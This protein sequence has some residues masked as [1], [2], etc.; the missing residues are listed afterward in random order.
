M[1]KPPNLYGGKGGCN[2]TAKRALV[3]AVVFS[4]LLSLVLITPLSAQG[5]EAVII[6]SGK[7]TAYNTN[8]E[9]DPPL[10]EY[11]SSP[12]LMVAAKVG[13]GAVVA[14]G[15]V[16]TSR[17]T[18][19]NDINN[20]A[21]NFDVLLDKAFQWMVPGATKVL[22]FEGYGVYNTIDAPEVQCQQLEDALEAKGYT[23][24]GDATT[25]ITSSLLSGYDIMVIP[26]MQLGESHTGG[27]PALLPDADVQAIKT[28]VEGGGGL[29]IMD[30]SDYGGHNYYK[31]HN[32][33]LTALDVGFYFQDDQVQDDT[34]QWGQAAYQPIAVVDTTTEIGSAYQ[35]ET[36]KNEIGLYSICSLRI[37]K[38]YEVSVMVSPTIK[39]GAAGEVLTYEVTI[40]NTGTKSDTYTL[41]AEDE[42]GWP[43]TLSK[44][45]ASLEP[46]ESTVVEVRVTV[47]EDLTEKMT[48]WI[49]LTT[50]GVSE[51]DA[52][53]RAI[54]IF[55]REKPP[56]PIVRPDVVR[57]LG[58]GLPTLLVDPPAVPVITAI[59]T[60]FSVDLTPREPWPIL[61]G[62][63]EF[64]PVSAAELIGNGRVIALSNSI[65]RDV[66]FDRPELANDEVM[67]M[68]VRWM[69][70][71]EDPR[72]H[73]LLYW[74]TEDSYH[75]P[76]GTAAPIVTKYVEMLEEGF[77]FEVGTQVGGEI[78]PELI[79]GYDVIQLA[80]ILR[81]LSAGEI[82]AVVDWVNDGGGLIIMCMA[83]YGGYSRP[84]YPNEV[85][86]ALDSGIRFQ[87]DELYDEDSWVV[88][89]PWFPQVYLLDPREAN[90]EFDVWFPGHD[91]A[92]YM[93]VKSMTLESARA[94]FRL[95]LTNVGTADSTYTIEVTETTTPEKLGWNLEVKPTEV[96][97]AVGENVEI[98]TVVTVPDIEAGR[99]RMDLKI[100]VTDAV[101]D[102]LTRSDRFAILGEGGRMPPE[103]KFEV[104]Q[105]VSHVD[106][107]EVTIVDVAW[108]GSA[109]AYIVETADGELKLAAEG[110]LTELPPSI[111]WDASITA[112]FSGGSDDALF[113]V[114]PDAT[115]N[116]DNV[117]NIPEPP[118]PPEPPHVRAYFYYPGQTPDELHCSYLAPENLMGWPLR[119][120]YAERL[121][122]I[123]LTWNM[124]DVPAD[125][126]IFLYRGGDL[127]ADMRA[128]E[129]YTFE[130]STGSYDFRIVVGRIVPFTLELTHGWNMISFPVLPEN[131]SPDAIFGGYYVLYGWD[132][133]NNRYVLHADSGSFIEPDPDVEAGV[134]Y[135]AYVLEDE[136]VTLL[137][138]PVDQL[139]LS[140]RQGW[141]LIGPP[142]GGS[143]IADPADDPDISVLPWAFTWNARER[144]YS[145]TQLLEAGRGYWVYAM[146]DCTLTL[147][148]TR[149]E[150]LVVN[151]DFSTGDATGW[152]FGFAAEPSYGS[153]PT[154]EIVNYTARIYR[155]GAGS[156]GRGGW[157]YQDLN[158]NVSDA[159]EL[160]LSCKVK[161]DYQSLSGTGVNSTEPPAFVE[162][163][164]TGT[165]GQDRYRWWGFYYL[166]TSSN[167]WDEKIPQGTWLHRSYDL[168]T[169]S[170]KPV[171]IKRVYIGGSGWDYDASFDDVSLIY[172]AA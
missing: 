153:E 44:N 158:V 98:Y 75:L 113:G 165:D 85:L 84:W 145:M 97:V 161:V 124:E 102:Y 127:V 133:E 51:D 96:E 92:I 89:G 56:Y 83:D 62:K 23:L 25:P 91:F 154:Y 171:V 37:E 38:D 130:A 12:P 54:N 137:G 47:P 33:I 80:E 79:G 155:M 87:D 53:F 103:A 118:A 60:G 21:P 46:G 143:S 67:S 5:A 71:W 138:A 31:V 126:S 146:R 99:K 66:Y 78:T 49:T 63:G 9:G 148:P 131:S 3:A 17:D 68:I 41:T 129:N 136:N 110:E 106:W 134:G 42:L 122:D 65:L 18:R 162:I 74:V 172:V 90:P 28:W 170:P 39:V 50:S 64:A 93:P 159:S 166:G 10:K 142:Y 27:N 16:S 157:L 119:I 120:E 109:W 8:L 123:T 19:W 6:V 164:Y 69:I 30:S 81:P 95:T 128:E 140:L 48:N 169:L 34:N 105:R 125:Y 14:T 36:G 167:P 11:A 135:W 86:E 35:S 100:K 59:E 147:L 94:L 72:G 116:F 144:G 104:G 139:T 160:V 151:G 40:T 1:C 88:D 61:Y 117:Y 7:D 141:D 13:S 29:L 132:A 152:T 114:R 32:K 111:E 115:D 168:T 52:R 77:G 163:L 82:Q 15:T 101:Q 108:D 24:T 22:W 150:E 26:Q 45:A 55:P 58:P 121:E 70:D 4:L 43:I 107:G 73:S 76:P 2:L 156:T 112:A 20:P 149:G 57:F